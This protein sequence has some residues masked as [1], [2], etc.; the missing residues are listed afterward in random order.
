MGLVKLRA[1]YDNAPLHGRINITQIIG[2]NPVQFSL[3]LYHEI[4]GLIPTRLSSFRSMNEAIA[5]ASLYGFLSQNWIV[6]TA[7]VP[8]A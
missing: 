1:S 8:D 7:T 2:M 5:Q 6:Q 3:T 4:N